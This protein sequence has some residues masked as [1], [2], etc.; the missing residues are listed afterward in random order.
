[1]TLTTPTEE[2]A[3]FSLDDRYRKVEGLIYITGVQ[4]LVRTILA[5]SRLDRM[6]GADQASFVSGYEGSPLAGFDLELQRHLDVLEEHRITHQPALNEELAATAVSGSQLARSVAD[7][8]TAGITGYWYGK[9]PGLDRA[10]DAFRHANMAGTDGRGGAVAFV[11]DD[12]AAKSSSV[13]CSSEFA[14]ADLAIPTLFPADPAEAVVHGLHAVELSRASGLWSAL[15]VNTVVADGAATTIEPR[16]WTAPDLSELP[17]GLVAYQHKPSAY[18]LGTTL[19]E[20]E[21]SM[22]RTRLPI[23]ME[24]V[25]RSGLNEIKGARDA[26]IGIVAAG[27]TYMALRQALAT[28]GLDDDELDRRGIRLL[29]LGVIFPLE[30]SVV[31]EFAEGLEEIVVV[32]DK[33][34]FLEDAIK[35]VLYGLP[36]APVVYGKRQADGAVLFNGLGEID[37]DTAAL[38]LAPLL[39]SAGIP[40][41]APPR[42]RQYLQL[43][44]AP[45]KPFFC[46]GCPHNSST[47]APEGSLVGAGI[48]CHTMLLLNPAERAGELAGITQMG[49]EGAY[50]FGMA[51]FVSQ[52]HFFQN[53]G[54]GTFAHSGSLAIRAAVASGINVTYKLLRNS[55]VAMT[56]GQEPIGERTLA[57]LVALLR[58]EGVA[59]II[60]TT[61]DTKTVRRQLGR[62]EDVRHRDGLLEAQSELAAV[63]G[64]TVL[65]HDQECAAELRRKRRRGKAPT[66]TQ[67]VL[68]NE[69]VCE[70]CGDC[71]K[72]SNCL[73]VHPVD[74]EFGRKTAIDQSSC[75]L[76]FS[77]L[78][79]DCPSF[80][81]IVPGKRTKAKHAAVAEP[82]EPQRVVSTDAFSMRIVG[83]G[84]TGV[85]TLA[86]VI[87]TAA[88]IEGLHVRALDQTGLAQKGGAVVS[89]L[90][91]R[92][93]PWEGSARLSYGQCDLYLAPDL[94]AGTE[95]VNLRV[96]DP[97]RTVA[98][99]S[100]SL[101]PTGAMVTDLSEATPD[102]ADLVSRLRVACRETRAIDALS[103]A[104]DLLGDEQYANVMLLGAAYQL[105][106]VPLAASTI[107]MAIQLNG[108]AVDAN[109]AAFRHGRS[110]VA[111]P[112]VDDAPADQSLDVLVSG[113]AAD[114][115][116]YQSAAYARRYTGTVERVRSQEE[117]LLGSEQLTEAV[118]RYLYKLMAY[119]DEYEVARLSLAPELKDSIA[120][121]FGAG[122]RYSY[123]L[124]PPVLRAMGLKHKISLGP[125]FR[126]AFHGLAG[127]RR[128]RGTALDPFGRAE[129]RRIERALISEY[130]QLVDE[131]LS[132]LTAHNLGVAVELLSLPD[133]VRGY[134]QIKLDNVAAYHVRKAELLEQFL[135]SA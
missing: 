87:A 8:K 63:P 21:A 25:R 86:Q 31:R 73:S 15:K 38:A 121:Q 33:R 124:H 76:D 9:A 19:A 20:L 114:L 98:V 94:I 50:W 44:A 14:L 13:P 64:V 93:E 53:L 107:E 83:I 127:M 17:G 26:R 91:L 24:Y 3:A 96:A 89:D 104:V 97:A 100:T 12:P 46:S 85:V 28:L 115:V 84:G 134:E 116:A 6:H 95:P 56:G 27:S 30:P 69:R 43:A 111:S 88:A 108:T 106:A 132:G 80:L 110:V 1:M 135:Q 113:R 77:C 40:V 54:D 105:G 90:T 125:W 78:A 66:P 58:A 70:G 92:K 45:R 29:K 32:E 120:A 123:R 34:S 119:K 2:L 101:A 131:V 103:L 48:G 82:P 62:N 4:A 99:A 39:A 5:R 118:A 81:T 55:A 7:L 74:T 109:I 36:N 65:I 51:P 122:A 112:V 61:E 128:L 68:I 22:H 129:V 35:S 41:T 126:P 52:Q 49:G 130:E 47:K 11:G 117:S 18:L 10:T 133:L 60:V 75:N 79:G 59:K 102:M 71:G 16:Y 67:R 72:K 42:P 37:S 23:A 57:Q